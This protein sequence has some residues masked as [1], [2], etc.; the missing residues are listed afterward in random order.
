MVTHIVA[1]NFKEGLTDEVKNTAASAIK[2]GL[3][4]LPA[5][6]PE[7]KKA[8]VYTKG[9]GGTMK[10]MMLIMFDNGIDFWSIPF[11]FV[12]RTAKAYSR[13]AESVKSLK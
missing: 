4:G 3:E 7:L 8:Q 10:D 2:A 1:W 5:L 6:I 13:H 9:C 11:S 12:R